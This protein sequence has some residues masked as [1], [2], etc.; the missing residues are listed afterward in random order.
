MLIL[1]WVLGEKSLGWFS[2]IPDFYQTPK[3]GRKLGLQAPTSSTPHYETHGELTLAIQ[4][5]PTSLQMTQ[6]S[7]H[8]LT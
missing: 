6:H 8:D 7:K 2:P 1:I 3:D 5:S 4:R